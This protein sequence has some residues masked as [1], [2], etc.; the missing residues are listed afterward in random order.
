MEFTLFRKQV[1][2]IIVDAERHR[3]TPR[4]SA[5]SGKAIR[6]WVAVF[7]GLWPIQCATLAEISDAAFTVSSKI[8]TESVNSFL[9]SLNRDTR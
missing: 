6:V 2:K 3:R 8:E 5:I 1:D 9:Q 7:F 4:L